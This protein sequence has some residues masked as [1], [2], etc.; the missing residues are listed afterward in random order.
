[1]VAEKKKSEDLMDTGILCMSD[2][3]RIVFT[4][5]NHFLVLLLLTFV[6]GPMLWTIRA[7]KQMSQVYDAPMPITTFRDEMEDDKRS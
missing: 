7:K 6:I 1:M 5:S 2:V 3:F 4:S